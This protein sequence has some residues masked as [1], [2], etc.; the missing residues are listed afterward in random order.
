MCY[1]STEKLQTRPDERN[2]STKSRKN[3]NAMRKENKY[4]GMLDAD[5]IKQVEMK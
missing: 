1:A 4:L 3:W 2:G 5:T